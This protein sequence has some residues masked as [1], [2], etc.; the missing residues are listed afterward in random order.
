MILHYSKFSKYKNKSSDSKVMTLEK[1]GVENFFRQKKLNLEQKPDTNITDYLPDE[2]IV[3]F[4]KIFAELIIEKGV[5]IKNSALQKGKILSF[6]RLNDKSLSLIEKVTEVKIDFEETVTEKEI[7]SHEFLLFDLNTISKI[8][9]FH[10]KIS[11]KTKIIFVGKT[12]PDYLENIIYPD[13][14]IHVQDEELSLRLLVKIITNE[15]SII[16][17]TRNFSD[18]KINS[19]FSTNDDL[20][21]EI[22]ISDI[23]RKDL[24]WNEKH[25]QEFR[26]YRILK[27]LENQDTDTIPDL[28]DIIISEKNHIPIKILLSDPEIKKK[29]Y[30]IDFWIKYKFCKY[31]LKFEKVINVDD[32]KL[33]YSINLITDKEV[34]DTYIN[35]IYDLKNLNLIMPYLLTEKSYHLHRIVKDYNII[36]KEVFNIET[37]VVKFI[38][39]FPLL[40][41]FFYYRNNELV[42]LPSD[43]FS[44]LPPIVQHF[45]Y[46]KFSSLK[47]V[48]H[49]KFHK[50]KN[51]TLD[52]NLD[53]ISLCLRFTRFHKLRNLNDTEEELIFLKIFEFFLSSKFESLSNCYFTNSLFLYFSCQCKNKFFKDQINLLVS[54]TNLCLVKLKFYLDILEKFE[55][56]FNTE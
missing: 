53:P 11:V 41:L 40:S 3:C 52:S 19:N 38:K 18:D 32:V 36:P 42:K 22:K 37:D 50:S 49:L 21:Y 39:S 2:K 24:R 46:F 45:T 29:N 56:S 6:I 20:F 31:F 26:K 44:K 28:C 4:D 23:F 25:H 43:E 54:D 15:F 9:D 30:L 8:K 33:K 35:N 17:P 7:I 10:E 14:L 47:Q 5:F 51:D 1:K 48:S 34:K 27:L 16:N 55:P 12:L 13:Q